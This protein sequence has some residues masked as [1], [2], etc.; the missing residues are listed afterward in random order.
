MKWAKTLQE[1]FDWP[2]S[3][4][5]AARAMIL[6]FARLAEPKQALSVV[7]EDPAD[8]RIIECA[9]ASGFDA[10][11]TGDKDLLRRANYEG[12]QIVTVA[13]FLGQGRER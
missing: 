7:T 5:A 9:A 10:I 12:I 6:S 11:V 13:Q 3:D 4:W 2:A 8:N 1:K